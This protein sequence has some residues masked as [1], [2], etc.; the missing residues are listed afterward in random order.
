[1]KT[2]LNYLPADKQAELEKVVIT[3]T[4]IVPVEMI[5]LFGSYARNDWV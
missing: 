5:I 3:I 2:D 1:M 4:L